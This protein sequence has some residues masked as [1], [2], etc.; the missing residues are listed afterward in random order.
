MSQLV[1]RKGLAQILDCA[2]ATTRNLQRS[3]AISPEMSVDGRE[4]F[5]AEK[6]RQLKARRDAHRNPR[7][8]RSSEPQ[9]AA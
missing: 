6:A 2:E 1:G 4:L 8:V 9:A 5:S 3:G 7:L